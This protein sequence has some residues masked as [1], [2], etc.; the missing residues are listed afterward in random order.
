MKRS[1]RVATVFTGAA[2]CAVGLAPA[3]HAAPANG[4]TAK[5]T[6]RGITANDCTAGERDW[7]HM[8]YTAAENHR[9]PACFAGTGVFTIPGNKRFTYFC[10]GNNSG[11]IYFKGGRANQSFVADHN[12]YPL[13]SDIVSKISIT[14]HFG[15]APSDYC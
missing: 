14:Q 7:A 4:A 2:A 8:Y 3:A 10:P 13:D 12:S 11:Y 15:T 6:P 9:T 5:I 1:F